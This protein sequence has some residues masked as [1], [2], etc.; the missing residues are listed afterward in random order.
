MRLFLG[1]FPPDNYLSYFRDVLR[2]YDKQ[3][4]NLR[5]VPMEQIHLTLKFFGADVSPESKDILLKELQKHSGNYPKPQIKINKVQF[6]FEYQKDPRHLL[7]K[8]EE[9]DS[10]I[11]F[12]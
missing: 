5:P 6:G 8:I 11:D 7:A 9:D 4:R 12:V 3:K 10:I 2:R 1:V